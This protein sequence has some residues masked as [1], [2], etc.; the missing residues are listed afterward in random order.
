MGNGAV[1]RTK[2]LGPGLAG[3]QRSDGERSE[4][5]TPGMPYSIGDSPPLQWHE[6][7]DYR[8]FHSNL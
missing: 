7:H 5:A 3:S 2:A 1:R 8:G 6:S 4:P